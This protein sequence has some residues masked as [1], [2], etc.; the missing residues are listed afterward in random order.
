MPRRNENANPTCECGH[1]RDGHY[2]LKRS[3]QWSFCRRRNRSG[4]IPER[5][6]CQNYSAK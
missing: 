1:A 6:P 4:T 5:C 2:R 3:K